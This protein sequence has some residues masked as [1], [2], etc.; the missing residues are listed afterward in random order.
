M[1]K[2]KNRKIKKGGWFRFLG[3]A[4]SFLV[5]MVLRA[6]PIALI[7]V[8]FLFGAFGV[9]K[10]LLADTHLKVREIRVVPA[11]VLPPQSVRILEDKILGKNILGIDLK[12]VASLIELGPGA[13]SVR[14][15]REMPDALR[16]EIGKRKPVANILLRQGGN[17]GIVAE[18]GV[19][20]ATSAVPDPAW[21]VIEDFSE[22]VKEPK[23]GM[24]IRNRGF[25]EALRFLDAFYSKNE[26]AQKEKVTRV[27]LDAY[28]N[29]TVRLG[30]GPDFQLG[31][32]PSE[33]FGVLTKAMH[34]FKTKPRENFEYIDLQFDERI[35]ARE[36]T[37]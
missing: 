25:V 15:V 21:I 30:E 12:K 4:F 20:V 1:S 27:M 14:V 23:I 11:D 9:K 24:Q 3:N 8:A 35:A 26:L 31:R 32:K 34:L 16:I 10:I 5:S 7:I 29:V 36:K 13:R 6:V 33:K 37:P 19:V 18:D 28:G 17:Y 2:K 22:A